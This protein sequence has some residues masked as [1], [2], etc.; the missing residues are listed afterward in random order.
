MNNNV[1]KSATADGVES[2]GSFNKQINLNAEKFIGDNL[3][4][5]SSFYVRETETHYDDMSNNGEVGYSMD[6]TMQAFQLGF[7][8]LEKFC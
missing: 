4:L 6:N 7:E 3:K 2:D 8:R 5:K 1:T